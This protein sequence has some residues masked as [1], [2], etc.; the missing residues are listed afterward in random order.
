MIEIASEKFNGPLEVL[1]QL[2]DERK[3]PITEISVSSVTEQF[4][5]YLETLEETDPDELADFLVIAARLL[6]MKSRALLPQFAPEPDEGPSLVDQLRLYKQ[7]VAVSKQIEKRWLAPDK[8]YGRVEPVRVVVSAELPANVTVPHLRASMV[9]LVA[10]LKPPK[11]LPRTL[12]DRTVSLK[13]KIEFVKNLILK[14][15]SVRFFDAIAQATNKTD[16]IV[17]FLAVL[18]LVKQQSI[19]IHQAEQ[20]GDIVIKKV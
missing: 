14:Q 13:E 7:F 16:V 18:E 1:L 8:S 19:S 15:G 5:Q 4:L 10:R 17:G 3:L 20:F 2:I 9:K 11:P 6:L 12:I